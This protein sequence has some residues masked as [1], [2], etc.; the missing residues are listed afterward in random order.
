MTP[1]DTPILLIVYQ[2]H[3][4]LLGLIDILRG[5]RPQRLYV[6]ADGPKNGGEWAACRQARSSLDRID[7]ECRLTRRFEAS[8]L[9]CGQGPAAA[10]SWFFEHEAEGIILE[11]DL[12]PHPDFFRFMAEMLE[13]FRDDERVMDICGTNRLGKWRDG[14]QSYL[15]SQWGSSC[16]WASW[17][18]AWNHFD[19]HIKAWD[20]PGSRRVIRD[21]YRRPLWRSY[22]RRMLERTRRGGQDVT[23]W[24][25]QWGLAKNLR[26]GLSVVPADNLVRNVGCDRHSTHDREPGHSPKAARETAGLTFPLRHPVQVCPDPG[27][28]EALLDKAISLRNYLSSMVPYWLKQRLK[29]LM[30]SPG[31]RLWTG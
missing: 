16:G 29:R 8:N 22:L 30:G 19:F 24:D 21:I 25:Y 4:P 18:R 31:E 23:W 15:F 14:G 7:W 11:D 28:D 20:D 6:F 5:I 26:G 3:S 10:I 1:C 17:R 9:G 13:R 12:L 27:F 2:R